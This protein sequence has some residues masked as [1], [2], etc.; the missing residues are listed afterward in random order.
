[1]DDDAPEIE[2]TVA[3]L[4]AAGLIS[5]TSA[6]PNARGLAETLMAEQIAL[7]RMQR[8]HLHT[9]HVRD[10]FLIA[11]DVALA[12]GGV[13]LIAI[14]VALL[15]DAWSSRSV[16][17]DPFDVPASFATQG[18][19]G[20]VIAS[21]L[22][23]RLKAIQD[24][25]RTSQSKR[26]VEDAWSNKIELQIP[27]AGI[28]I[29]DLENLLHRWL[30]HDEHISGSIVA[31][32]S[33]IAFTIRGDEFRAKSFA[34]TPGDLDALISKAA[35]YLYG[36]SEPYLFSVYLVDQGRDAE[37]ITVARNAFASAS[38]EDKPLLLNVW[39]NALSD[40]G[41]YREAIEKYQEAL[42]LKPNLWIAY[43]G[44]MG[45]EES[46]GE[47]E[48]LVG[49]G[50]KMEVLAR[51]GSW[52]AAHVPP[53]YWENL[54]YFLDDWSAFEADVAAD[55]AE[56]GGQGTSIA[57][58]APLY[59]IALAQVH[60]WHDTELELQTSPGADQDPY[61]RAQTGFVRGIVALDRDDFSA[62]TRWLRGADKIVSGDSSVAANMTSPIACWLALA[63]T[64]AGSGAVADAEIAR[65]G[66]FV[67]CYRFKGDIA[68]WRGNWPQAVEDYVAAVR[69]APS[70]PSSYESWGEALVRHGQN[71]AAIAK[72]A[73]AHKRGP[74]WADPLKH[75]GD[76]LAAEGRL[77]AALEKYEQASRFA[78]NWGALHLA[79]GRA[80][81]S[82]HRHDE[83]LEQFRRAWSL[84][85]TAKERSSI[86][87]CCQ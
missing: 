83:A 51:R 50:K 36:G 55:M 24:A 46:L 86:W 82:L 35:E 52:F 79:W 78:P 56:S 16:I 38:S 48:V 75:W 26:A 60:N 27:E 87:G 15:W 20:K 39:G 45:S 64:K 71:D 31:S 47:E 8:E 29:A 59:A 37:A 84:D 4:T 11:F 21:A 72:F 5:T 76:A 69:L 25:T 14:I 57:E 19:S 70:I 62:A 63:E 74:H 85:L 22:L 81:D 30:A 33:R 66:H 12:L 9:Q 65:G 67:D 80:L 49:V 34:G 10:R 41:R 28:S 2:P 13:V 73:A 40:L 7:A 6:D 42:R 54:D 43:D 61:V 53:A 68:D 18:Q 17:V 77:D 44:T 23:D 58:D 3:E 32:G 1:M